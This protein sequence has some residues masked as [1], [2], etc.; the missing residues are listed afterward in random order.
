MS[1]EKVT[2]VTL[3]HMEYAALLYVLR[4]LPLPDIHKKLSTIY[5]LDRIDIEFVV[6]VQTIDRKD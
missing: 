3:D 4:K 1:S 5:P 6:S 2:T